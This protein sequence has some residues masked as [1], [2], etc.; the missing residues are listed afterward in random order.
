MVNQPPVVPDVSVYANPQ[1]A[2][3]S[4]APLVQ[5]STYVAP[6]PQAQ[7]AKSDM[8]LPSRLKRRLSARRPEPDRSGSTTPRRWFRW[9]RQSE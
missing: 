3:T 9:G 8:D 1:F 5:S 2:R 7:P 4:I 6:M